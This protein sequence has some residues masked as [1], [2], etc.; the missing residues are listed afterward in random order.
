MAPL[1]NMALKWG[2]LVFNFHEKKYNR[3]PAPYASEM[4]NPTEINSRSIAYF[5]PMDIPMINTTIPTKWISRKPIKFSNVN[6]S[7]G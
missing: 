1:N 7:E 5:T 3:I 4:R 2:Y 6:F